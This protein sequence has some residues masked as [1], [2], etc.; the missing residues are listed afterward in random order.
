MKR[1]F[2]YIIKNVVFLA[3]FFIS[4]GCLIELK[5]METF[6]ETTQLETLPDELLV[7][8]ALGFFPSTITNSLQIVNGFNELSKLMLTNKRFYNVAHDAYFQPECAIK[9]Y[10]L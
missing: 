10:F 1:F 2:S 4:T 8:V 7:N 9:T 5:A 6:E 3:I